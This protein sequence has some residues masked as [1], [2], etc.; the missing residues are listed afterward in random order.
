MIHHSYTSSVISLRTPLSFND[1]TYCSNERCPS[2]YCSCCCSF[3]INSPG[4]IV[5][6]NPSFLYGLRQSTL[7]QWPPSR[8][9]ILG[10]GDQYCFRAPVSDV[11]RFCDGECSCVKRE[12]VDIFF[13]RCKEK[14]CVKKRSVDVSVNTIRS[15]M[16]RRDYQCSTIGDAE[17]MLSLLGEEAFEECLD[18][19]E[20]RRSLS[21]HG[22]VI[23]KQNVV[24][25]DSKGR[26][27]DLGS[28]LGGPSSKYRLEVGKVKSKDEVNER[29][30]KREVL[31]KG[32]ERRSRRKESSS[33]NLGGQL[34]VAEA[35]SSKLRYREEDYRSEERENFSKEEARWSR[36]HESSSSYYSASDTSDLESDVEVEIQD[37]RYVGESSTMHE[38]DTRQFGSVV[39]GEENKKE[40]RR[41]RDERDKLLRSGEQVNSR[42]GSFAVSD[43]RKKLEGIVISEE[44]KNDPKSYI[45]ER[46]QQ[47]Q[48]IR[49]DD[50]RV[51]SSAE[52]DWRKKSEKRLTE[53]SAEETKA[54]KDSV[55]RHSQ[56]S[57]AHESSSAKASRSEKQFDY[58]EQGSSSRVSSHGQLRSCIKKDDQVSEYS[59]SS[60]RNEQSTQTA[61]YNVETTSNMQ[62]RSNQW[63]DD[64]MV[65]G[66]SVEE[67]GC[68]YCKTC[69]RTMQQNK[70]QTALEQRT[71]LSQNR[72][73]VRSTATV[74]GQ[75]KSR[76][77]KQKSLT[78]LQTSVQ[79]K[80]EHH[81]QMTHLVTGQVKT[82]RK[83][84]N[85][86]EAVDTHDNYVESTLSS[87]QQSETRMETLEQNSSSLISRQELKGPLEKSDGKF[88]KE[89]KSSSGISSLQAHSTYAKINRQSASEQHMHN[90]QIYST[91]VKSEK[92]LVQ[93]HRYIDETIVRS[94]LGTEVERPIVDAVYTGNFSGEA[95]ASQPSTALIQQFSEGETDVALQISTLSPSSD[96]LSS[97]MRN[98]FGGIVQVG[99]GSVYIHPQARTPSAADEVSSGIELYVEPSK[100]DAIGS[101]E[102]MEE[103]SIHI[104]SGFVEEMKHEGSTSQT[105]MER[106]TPQQ[107][108]KHQVG[109]SSLYVHPQARTPS[110]FD[111]VSC[112]RSESYEYALIS[113]ERMEE[114]AIQI[115]GEFVEKMQHEAST[116]ESTIMK[117][118]SQLDSRPQDEKYMLKGS[119]QSDSENTIIEKQESRH[120]SGRS[121]TK[122]P[123]DDMWDAKDHFGQESSEAESSNGVS[124]NVSV[125][126]TGKSLWNIVAGIFRVLH[127][128]TQKSSVKE[129]GR[130]SSNQSASGE[131]W[132]SEDEEDEANGDSTKSASLPEEPT[133]SVQP[134]QRRASTKCQREDLG[135][136]ILD[137]RMKHVEVGASSSSS[138]LQTSSLSGGVSSGPNTNWNIAMEMSQPTPSALMVP[139][140]GR[141][142]R[143]HGVEEIEEAGHSA[144]EQGVQSFHVRQTGLKPASGA[145]DAEVK[146]RKLQRSNQVLNERYYEWETAYRH[147]REQRKVDEIFMREA[148]VEAKKAADS[149]EVPVGAILVQNGNV[150]ARGYNLVEELRDSTAH[151]EMI[152]IR[153][154]SNFLRTWRLSET[155]LYVTLEPCPMC[156]G[157]ILQ[158]RVGTLVWGA[159]NRLLGADGSWI[160]LFPGVEGEE[161]PEVAEKPAAPVHPF[162]PNMKIRRGVLEAECA[163]IMQQFF[164]LRRRREKK[165]EESGQKPGLLHKM[166][167]LP[168][169]RKK[170]SS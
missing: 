52:W 137:D 36:R 87:R 23:R 77:E 40:S 25:E 128:E 95:S 75:S 169:I 89:T 26:K 138:V 93:K 7:I 68:E 59:K 162:H 74:Q 97:S 6:I 83:L 47:S 51:A 56:M 69:G 91:K 30:E 10:A 130:G 65:V 150:I 145:T 160:R 167:K 90:E 139:H 61:R 106:T 98:D 115:V 85:C 17:A 28:G 4:F 66:Q 124:S 108:S 50:S 57:Q 88:I 165:S 103:S 100:E 32:E 64:M 15:R 55:V 118:P 168:V 119:S 126:R 104:F 53:E 129:G 107:D 132:S 94:K 122:G 112:N 60:S 29:R 54:R 24:C 2:S 164:Q 142:G 18:V 37:E 152:C 20:R 155:T 80:N 19:R 22:N 46:N 149:W 67:T 127:A 166:L 41:Y 156:A 144:G 131:A 110:S 161:R 101:A 31:L 13:G 159:P 8:R 12:R 86:S 72:D 14:C 123:S 96:S 48:T 39:I 34:D 42:V 58:Q 3:S 71:E 117:K 157:A 1:Y 151:A 78:S 27:E 105:R 154:A 158:A 92:E 81:D 111:E 141:S 102:C 82:R 99:T 133:S 5:P 21:K 43:S 76:L 136:V 44:T 134:P 147:E 113:A 116:S 140:A 135:A 84:Q 146:K 70:T 63:E 16:G 35:V 125:R 62:R 143:S 11:G 148:L 114:S 33:E 153:E 109:A 163:G 49:H 121:E 79:Q 73:D 120:S 170:R 45:D 38:K 9:L